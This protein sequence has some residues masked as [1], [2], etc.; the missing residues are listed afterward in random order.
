MVGPICIDRFRLY[1]PVSWIVLHVIDGQPQIEASYLKPASWLSIILSASSV[2][3]HIALSEAVTTAWWFAA[4]RKKATTRDIYDACRWAKVSPPY[5]SL[6]SGSIMSH[7]QFSSWLVFLSMVDKSKKLEFDLL[8]HSRSL[9]PGGDYHHPWC[10][11]KFHAP[12][13]GNGCQLAGRLSAELFHGL[14]RSLCS[15]Y[16]SVFGAAIT[17]I[18]QGL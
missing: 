17:N 5:S 2:L 4:S 18:D 9:A 15:S 16:L 7:C 6:A 8:K 10:P 1:D 11:Q 13:S 14:C 12:P 3:L